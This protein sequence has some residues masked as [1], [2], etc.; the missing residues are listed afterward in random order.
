MLFMLI[1]TYRNA[2]P[3]PV[4]RRLRERGR[5]TM[6]GVTYL[7]S[8]VTSDLTRCFQI[9][10]CENR[11]LLDQW[12]ALWDDL[13]EFDVIEVMTSAEAAEAVARRYS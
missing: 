12:M 11:R 1:E 7:G 10:D 5:Q 3:A 2:D 13:V 4:Y 8:W 9:M 6:D